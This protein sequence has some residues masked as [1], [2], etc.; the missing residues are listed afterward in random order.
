MYG[1]LGTVWG[2]ME[3][4]SGSPSKQAPSL[5]AMA[6]GVAGA[7]RNDSDGPGPASVDTVGNG[8]AVMAHREVPMA[9]CGDIW[10]RRPGITVIRR[11]V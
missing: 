2:V 5:T 7:L 8:T 1:L 11:S 9:V 6:P 3:T 10:I 4:F